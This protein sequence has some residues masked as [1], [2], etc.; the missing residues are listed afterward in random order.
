MGKEGLWLSYFYKELMYII[1][2]LEIE[3]GDVNEGVL[4]LK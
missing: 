4:L 3:Y 1:G 2:C